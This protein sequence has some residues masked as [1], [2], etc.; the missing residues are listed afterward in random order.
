MLHSTKLS[1]SKHTGETIACVTVQMR[2][3]PLKVD[4]EQ[5]KN[6]AHGARAMI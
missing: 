5:D 1:D 4:T 3:I 6:S 2:F